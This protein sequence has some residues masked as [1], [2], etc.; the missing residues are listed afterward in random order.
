MKKI[1]Q[2]WSLKAKMIL[3]PVAAGRNTKNAVEDD[4][5]K[6]SANCDQMVLFKV[7]LYPPGFSN[8]RIETQII[9]EL[10]V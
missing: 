6:Y 2:L 3:V 7:V 10:L 9:I 5:S 4:K 8:V 1:H